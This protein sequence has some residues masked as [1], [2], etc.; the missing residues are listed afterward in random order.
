MAPE[1]RETINDP[2]QELESRYA[3]IISRA[4]AI[5]ETARYGLRHADKVSVNNHILM[6]RSIDGDADSIKAAAK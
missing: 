6:L 2:M 5:V 3:R 4:A 1:R